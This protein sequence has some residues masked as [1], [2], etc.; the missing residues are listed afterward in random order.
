MAALAMQLSCG[1]DCQVTGPAGSFATALG[2]ALE[3]SRCVWVLGAGAANGADALRLALASAL[4]RC[5][6]DDGDQRRLSAAR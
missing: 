4:Q 1:D 2:V 3:R 5:N 6:S